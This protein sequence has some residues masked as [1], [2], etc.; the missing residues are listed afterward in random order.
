MF[1]EIGELAINSITY[2]EFLDKSFADLRMGADLYAST[3]I[4]N[5]GAV[6]SGNN[7]RMKTRQVTLCVNSVKME[8]RE[9]GKRKMV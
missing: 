5:R 2:I 9:R 6:I 3:P 1:L 8:T 7:L 4:V